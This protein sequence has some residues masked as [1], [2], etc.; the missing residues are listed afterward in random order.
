ML[1]NVKLFTKE[2]HKTDD[3]F[4]RCL[5]HGDTNEE[6]HDN[7]VDGETHH[8]EVDEAIHLLLEKAEFQDKQDAGYKQSACT[9]R[10]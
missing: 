3:L 4:G 9:G 1:H 2:Q 10:P 7:Q 8:S 5:K 6:S